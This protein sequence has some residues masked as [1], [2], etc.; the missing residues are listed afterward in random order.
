MVA[1]LSPASSFAVRICSCMTVRSAASS[2]VQLTMKSRLPVQLAH[3]LLK[4]A[5]GGAVVFNSSVAGG[6]MAM[7]TGAVYAMTK[8]AC[9]LCCVGLRCLSLHLRAVLSSPHSDLPMRI[10]AR[11]TFRILGSCSD[12]IAAVQRQ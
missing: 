2:G 1:F 10:T 12:L 3:P 5:G 4:A 7:K 11:A 6:P 8:G 9:E